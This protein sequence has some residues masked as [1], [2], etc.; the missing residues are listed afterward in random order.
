MPHKATTETCVLWEL[1]TSNLS[2]WGQKLLF[3]LCSKTSLIVVWLCPVIWSFQGQHEKFAC[4]HSEQPWVWSVTHIGTYLCMYRYI[5][6]YI[7][8]Y[9]HTYIY[10]N[11][12]GLKNQALNIYNF[13]SYPK[14][15]SPS[16][17]ALFVAMGS[18]HSIFVLILGK[19]ADI[20]FY[21][22]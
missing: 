2:H 3:N 5:D 10:C 7:C 20:R 11:S 1:K 17:E 13:G 6:I 12:D 15:S 18:T 9:T 16:A 4:V 14:Q 8:T 21:G 19:L 22:K